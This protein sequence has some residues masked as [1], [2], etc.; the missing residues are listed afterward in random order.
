LPPAGRIGAGLIV[1]MT[2]Y[3]EDYLTFQ[4]DL[5]SADCVAALDEASLWSA[6]FGQLLLEHV[7]M[8]LHLQVLDVG[9]GAGF[10]TLELAQR[11]GPTCGVVGLDPWE[12]ALERARFKARV[13][14]VRNVEFQ[15][16]GAAAM[17][18]ES[19]QFDLVVSNLGLNNFDDPPAA[20]RECRRVMKPG[21]R[22]VL[23]TNLQ[24]H[25]REFY[26]MFESTLQRLQG[27]EA[28][29][30]LARHVAHRATIDSVRSLFAHSGLDVTRVLE[31]TCTMRFSD[32]TALLRHYFIK[33]GFLDGWRSVVAPSERPAVFAAL[34]AALNGL[35]A[36]RGELALTIPM[37]CVEGR[38]APGA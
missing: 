26:E 33:L 37:A 1:T 10:P 14:G 24:G 8:G 35:A 30:A 13:C 11:L 20:L 31:R 7:P 17:P 28:L 5:A 29:A 6:V 4:A 3:T 23:T 22:L 32:G 34:E 16:G 18:F 15:L 2:S 27:P 38:V 21:A 19:G 25:M 9:C 12:A 36:S